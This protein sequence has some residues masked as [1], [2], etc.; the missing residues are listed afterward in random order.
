MSVII[1]IL[2]ILAIVAAAYLVIKSFERKFSEQEER[3]ESAL[4]SELRTQI[5]QKLTENKSEVTEAT[6]QVNERLTQ[7]S[8]Y[9]MELNKSVGQFTELGKSMKDFQDLFLSQKSRGIVGEQVLNELLKMVL[10][11]NMY[12]LQHRFSDGT[13]VDAVVKLKDGLIP[14]DAKFP[15][16]NF[17]LMNSAETEA[18]RNAA[19]REFI[20]DVKNHID[21][22]SKKYILP[23]EGTLEFAVL[24]VPIES[25]Y[26]SISEDAAL[27]GYAQEKKIW[28]LSP[29][30]FFQLLQI[31][32]SV[33]QHAKANELAIQA[34]KAI[35]GVQIEAGRFE[36]ELGKLTTHI[37]NAKNMSDSVNSRFQKL[38]GKIENVT[39][40]ELEETKMLEPHPE[41]LG[42][43]EPVDN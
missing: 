3:R 1:G 12:E 34:L 19:R 24:Y 42:S 11:A 23:Q 5:D 32:M 10:P 37:T 27:A 35:K 7:A 18:E 36:T 8:Q 26:N 43:V 30:N 29:N 6:R 2:I 31:V 22:I 28:I 15:M 14:V 13:R 38:A 41:H 40:L 39:T 17:R 9:I 20:K 33:Y 25:V 4:V 21:T 16:E